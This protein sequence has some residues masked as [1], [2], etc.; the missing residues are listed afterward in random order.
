MPLGAIPC[1][2]HSA[3][4][5]GRNGF[6]DSLQF[7]QSDFELRCRLALAQSP[8]QICGCHMLGTHHD[9]LWHIVGMIRV[10]IR[11]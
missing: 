3:E 5:R 6:P 4:Y 2:G 9:P 7:E 11:E 1:C 10:D 8:L